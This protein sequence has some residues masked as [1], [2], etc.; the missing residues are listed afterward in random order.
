[1]NFKFEYPKKY[2]EFID[3]YLTIKVNGIPK[4]KLLEHLFCYF[5]SDYSSK[6]HHLGN[7]NQNQND[8]RN[9]KVK[10]KKLKK[11]NL[12]LNLKKK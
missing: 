7:Q 12:N 11:K 6:T 4:G 8:S 5:I 3:S 2:W 9:W 1:L 10:K